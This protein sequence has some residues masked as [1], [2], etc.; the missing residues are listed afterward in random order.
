M[1]DKKGSQVAI[2]IS[3]VIFFGFLIF[4]FFFINQ[5]RTNSSGSENE[6]LQM[7]VERNLID[8]SSRNLTTFSVSLER[9]PRDGSCVEIDVTE[10]SGVLNQASGKILVK[11]KDG[12]PIA[13]NLRNDEKIEIDGIDKFYKIYYSNAFTPNTFNKNCQRIGDYDLG[14]VKTI[15]YIFKED[16]ESYADNYNGAGLSG[17]EFGVQASKNF[18]FAL[19]ESVDD[20]IEGDAGSNGIIVKAYKGPRGSEEVYSGELPI[21][22]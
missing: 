3:F 20:G 21:Q 12:K 4:V 9:T 13:A 1:K 5:F 6:I 14:L 10:L 7:Q 18:G 19:K 22:Y 2:I 16:L 11:D 17:A 8:K 15:N